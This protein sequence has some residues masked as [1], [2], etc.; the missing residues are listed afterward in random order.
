MDENEY[1]EFGGQWTAIKIEILQK[2]LNAYTQALKAKPTIDNPFKLL[3]I[4]AFAGAGKYF[5]KRQKHPDVGIFCNDSGC[6]LKANPGS[7]R[8]ALEIQRP[9]YG[10][11]FIEKNEKNVS[12]LN[13]LKEEY[14]DL[15]SKIN[16]IH[17]DSSVELKKIIETTSW[18][19]HRAVLFLD[20]FALDVSW[21][22]IEDVAKTSSI[23]MWFLFSVQAL[24]RMLARD[25]DIDHSWEKKIDT[26]FGDRSWRREFYIES[27]QRSILDFA[28][29]IPPEIKKVADFNTINSYINKRLSGVFA[30]VAKEPRVF[31]NSQNSPIFSLFFAV[32]NENG[33][34]TALKIANS[35]LKNS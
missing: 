23:D 15:S 20:P 33:K 34:S 2:Y 8:V 3:Y 24:K 18:R 5:P 19:M 4:D 31:K 6:S 27:P 21:S 12:Q 28:G 14:P 17:G 29:N 26:V 11:Y 9:F 7:A 1:Q 32:A 16:I 10:Y 30:G 13:L 35:I 25:G 22:T